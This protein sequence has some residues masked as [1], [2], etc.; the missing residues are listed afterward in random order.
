METQVIEGSRHKR[1]NLPE[2]ESYQNYFYVNICTASNKLVY[3]FYGHKIKDN[4]WEITY[5][6]R[7]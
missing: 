2:A 6:K 3:V 5:I 1:F 7:I 4:K